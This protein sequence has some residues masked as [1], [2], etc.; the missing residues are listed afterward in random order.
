M[1]SSIRDRVMDGQC[2]YQATSLRK[3]KYPGGYVIEPQVGYY[4]QESVYVLDVKSLY[5]S[6]MISH[7]I[8]F[9]TV[10]CHCCK[11]NPE[12]KIGD[13]MMN[14]VNSGLVAEDKRRDYWICIEPNYK[15]IVP[16]L[17]QHFR[18]ERFRQQEAGNE[19]M[20]LALK[21]L[22][23]GC[24]GVFGS[25]FFEY[26]DYRVAELTTAFGRDALQQMQH[27]AREVY[28]FNII[29]GDT[30]SI[31]VTGVKKQNDIKK[32]IAECSILLDIDV[33]VSDVYKKFLIVK[34][35]HYIGIPLDDTKKPIIKG[36]E[37]I[38]RDRPQWINNIQ[39]QFADDINC[40][41]NP[42]MNIQYQHTAMEFG[43]VP[44]QD[45]EIKL[46]LAKNYG[47]YQKNT[48]QRIV[49]SEWNTDQGDT[50][51]Y[52]KSDTPGGGSSDPK[53]LSR[54]KYLEM[55]RTTVEDSLQIMGYNY[56]QDVVGIRKFNDSGG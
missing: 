37:G 22:I 53:L 2:R 25:N 40:G 31:F 12:A 39:K 8:S 38:K 1:S 48:L 26:S 42:T 49:G 24:Y 14:S 51:K 7:N 36:M 56:M 52:Y 15:G 28:G 19:P 6:M 27:I 21:N 11:D 34:K 29:Y 18:D 50:I 54:K 30:D 23:N 20:Q 17:L 4:H 9:D 55:L 46:T 16:R 10:I 45:L 41:K 5:P 47:K 44:L 3:R 35:K 33:E 13:K 32:F 43:Q